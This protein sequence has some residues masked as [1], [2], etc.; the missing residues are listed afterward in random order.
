MAEV[1]HK[2]R[3]YCRRSTGKS[4]G[5][6]PGFS[7]LA[8][9]MRREYGRRR[10]LIGLQRMPIQMRTSESLLIGHVRAAQPK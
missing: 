8:V 1:I 9:K 4:T 3:L 10:G 2:Q 5:R 7:I 6:F